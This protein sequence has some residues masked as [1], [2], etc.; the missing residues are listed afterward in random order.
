MGDKDGKAPWPVPLLRRNHLN[1][2]CP[3]IHRLKRDRNGRI[4][5]SQECINSNWGRGGGR[6]LVRGV[7]EDALVFRRTL[8]ILNDGVCV[9]ETYE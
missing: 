7:I 1:Q 2:K 8:E 5:A 3:K 4:T 6:D 9:G